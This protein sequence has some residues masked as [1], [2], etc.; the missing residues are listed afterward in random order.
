MKVGTSIAARVVEPGMAY[1]RT[2]DIADNEP[3]D[4]TRYYSDM[5]LPDGT[6]SNYYRDKVFNKAVDEVAT[7][8]KD[9]LNALDNTGSYLALK[10]SLG[11]WNLDKGTVDGN[12]PHFALWNGQTEFPFN[13]LGDTA[14]HNYP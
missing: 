5:T 13:C 6:N 11:E 2:T 4:K 14:A 3:E 8:L 12:N 1:R 10:K 9:F 7:R